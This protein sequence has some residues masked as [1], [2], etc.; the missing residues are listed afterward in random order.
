MLREKFDNFQIWA[1][2]QHV[3]TGWSNVRNMLRSTMLRWMLRTFGGGLN[4]TRTHNIRR[5]RAGQ[6]LKRFH[7]ES[8]PFSSSLRIT[9]LIVSIPF[10]FW[11][12]EYTITINVNWKCGLKKS[13]RGRKVIQN[14]SYKSMTVKLF[15]T[16]IFPILIGQ[17]C[18]KTNRRLT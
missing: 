1:N 17:N 11:F 18:I 4:V 7:N 12:T 14:K 16:L 5:P 10:L 15:Y 13:L 3:A 8:L 9:T 6:R 2:T